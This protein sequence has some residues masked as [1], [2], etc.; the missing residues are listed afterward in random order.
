MVQPPSTPIPGE[1]CEFKSLKET[2]FS[3]SFIFHSMY[4]FLSVD[5]C[6]WFRRLPFIFCSHCFG[7]LS[8]GYE[9]NWPAGFGSAVAGVNWLPG[10]DLYQVAIISRIWVRLCRYIGRSFLFIKDL[11]KFQKISST[12]SA[13]L[14]TFFY[15]WPQKMSSQDPDP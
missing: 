1:S 4:E 15:Q 13:C 14:T 9:I 12:Y 5:S 8:G 11:K 2:V 10:S 6:F 7:S 3:I